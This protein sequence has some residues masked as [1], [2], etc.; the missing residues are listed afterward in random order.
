MRERGGSGGASKPRIGRRRRQGGDGNNQNFR[1]HTHTHTSAGGSF[2]ESREKIS[3]T[4]AYTY[5]H[6]HTVIHSVHLAP[7][8]KEGKKGRKSGMSSTLTQVHV[9]VFNFSRAGRP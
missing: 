6:T 2:W 4:L 5:P 9:Y 3:H 8:Q 1:T 7:K